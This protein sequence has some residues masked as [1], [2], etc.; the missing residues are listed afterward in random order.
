M[1]IHRGIVQRTSAM[2]VCQIR[3]C[4]TLE[5]RLQELKLVS[6]A[7]LNLGVVPCPELI[8]DC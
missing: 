3:V 5:Q 6:G 4:G 8:E 2:L 1:S 7:G